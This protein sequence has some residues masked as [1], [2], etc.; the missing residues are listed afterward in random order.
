M[1]RS[2]MPVTLHHVAGLL[3]DHADPSV[4]ARGRARQTAVAEN[5]Q[6]DY[7]PILF[8]VDDSPLL[9]QLTQ[10]DYDQEFHSADK[11]LENQLNAL[12]GPVLARSD[13]Q[14][15]VRANLGTGFLATA[16][17]L[18]PRILPH[19]L[20]WLTEHLDRASYLRLD[21]PDILDHLP[22]R[23]LFPRAL[24]YYD[25]SR[26]VFAQVGLDEIVRFYLPDTQ[27][28]F[29]LAHLVV[30]H[31]IFTDLYDDPAF[32]RQLVN[33]CT[34]LYCRA[35]HLL[36]QHLGEEPARAYHGGGMY[37]ASAGIRSCEDSSTL[38]SPATIRSLIQP[39]TGAVA[40]EFGGVFV[41]FCG[42][43]RHLLDALMEIPE[44]R[45][46]NFGNPECY[47]FA[48]VLPKL[49]S[50]GKYYHGA[51][52]RQREETMEQYFGR[53]V[54]YLGG[55]RRGLV[56]LPD[57]DGPTSPARA[58]EIMDLWHQVQDRYLS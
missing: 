28:P 6:P 42:K 34:E 55:E 29:D 36:K 23:G 10:Y 17:G 53:V 54:G 48:T 27:G 26:E 22:G 2:S 32:V 44:A 38:V 3:L 31:E 25:Y 43:N 46:I 21:V 14:L 20:P 12:L 52:P 11:M 49:I 33:D 50:Q 37:L 13:S 4:L 35:T 30:G 15:T 51:I 45:C 5:R 16:F 56:L 9:D 19:T 8:A 24:A 47:D 39:A 57:L 18:E 41:H 1:S 58:I 40:R 7:L